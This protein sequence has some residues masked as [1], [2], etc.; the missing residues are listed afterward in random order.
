M[1]MTFLNKL[2]WAASLLVAAPLAF[3]GYRL[4]TVELPPNS[5][6]IEI[7]SVTFSP[8]GHLY[9]ANRRGEIWKA[10]RDGKNWSRFASG[11]HEPLGLLVE[12]E[13]VAYVMQRPELTRVEDTDGDGVADTVTMVADNWGITGNYHEFPY[14]LKRDKEGNFLGALGLSSGGQREFSAMKLARGPVQKDQVRQE[15]QWSVVPYRGWS[16]K[17]TPAGE[18]IPW[19]HGFRQAVGIGASPEGEFFVVDTQ[20]DWVASSGLIHNKQGG[21]FGHPAS[22][23][24]IPGGAPAIESDEALAQTRTP[25]AVMLPHGAVGISPGEPVWDTSAGRFGPFHGQVFIGDFSNLISRV[26]MEKIAGEYQGAA[27]PFFRHK[28]LRMGNMRMAFSPDGVLYMGQAS[29]GSGQGLQRLVWD[30]KAPVEVQAIK[31]GDRGFSLEFTAPMNRGM[32]A[33][34]DSY[35]VK[36]FRYLY[37]E[38]YGSP[39]I[40]EVPVKIRDLKVAA[41][42]RRVE[43]AVEDLKPGH[44]YEFQLDHLT[45]DSGEML[46]NA[47][48]FYT[49]NR[50]LNGERFAGPFTKALLTRKQGEQMAAIDTAAGKLVY[51]KFC[52][53]CH[54]ENGTGGGVAADFANDKNRLAKSD[55]ELMR[56][57]KLGFEGAKM[58]MPPFGSVLS[59]PEIRNVL[60]YIREA[61]DPLRA[62]GR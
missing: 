10:D 11:L 34:A 40:D 35:F 9:V 51:Q 7:F 50:L 6:S 38:K 61:F 57:I 18:F 56:S 1:S 17:V 48:G 2:T 13:R 26:F 36:R 30:G 53:A 49:L 12:S 22:R 39:R 29:W 15:Q 33:K 24:W 42:G 4:E 25:W 31:L 45:T 3:A 8:D 58:V 20:G 16:F 32:L 62:R 44:V 41:D 54:L 55:T 59:E 60:A 23:K 43:M 14:G 5:A 46:G 21:F 27:F 28:D 52:M 19:S 37:H 47:T